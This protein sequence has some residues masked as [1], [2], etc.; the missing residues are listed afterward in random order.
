M[1]CGPDVRN[2]QLPSEIYTHRKFPI[3]ERFLERLQKFILIRLFK[4]RKSAWIKVILGLFSLKLPRAPVK[5]ERFRLKIESV[6]CPSPL[7]IARRWSE[8]VVFRAVF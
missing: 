6:L 1:N 4:L 7:K 3:D 8:I 2:I 5:F